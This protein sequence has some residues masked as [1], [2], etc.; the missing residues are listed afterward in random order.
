MKVHPF[1]TLGVFRVAG[2]CLGFAAAFA[3]AG[4]PLQQETFIG[5]GDTHYDG[6]WAPNGF[7]PYHTD[8]DLTVTLASASPSAA[9]PEPGSVM[10]IVAGAG[11]LGMARHR[12]RGV[13]E[14]VRR[15][16][17]TQGLERGLVT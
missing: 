4:E 14:R 7:A 12:T 1:L 10:L 11:L 3:Q 16:P 9:V 13:V 17:G 2:L 5:G 15:I 6:V 8:A